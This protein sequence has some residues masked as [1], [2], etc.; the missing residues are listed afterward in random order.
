MTTPPATIL[1]KC[2]EVCY[3]TTVICES[4]S[5]KTT[6]RRLAAVCII[7]GIWPLAFAGILVRPLL[8]NQDIDGIVLRVTT[9]DADGPG[10]LRSALEDDRPR[11]VVFEV[12][13]VIDLRGRSLV[14]RN[15]HLT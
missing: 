7:F 6:S 15:P 1:L 3:M 14:V 12:G 9:L 11:L 13:G 10:S 2:V 5:C 4:S 8:R